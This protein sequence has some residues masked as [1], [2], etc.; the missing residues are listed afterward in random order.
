MDI[1]S[2]SPLTHAQH[3]MNQRAT[4]Q[5]ELV[6]ALVGKT[7]VW[8]TSTITVRTSRNGLCNLS[9]HSPQPLSLNEIFD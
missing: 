7:Q 8:P 3:R 4:C 9:P 5:D 6:L 1:H 2:R